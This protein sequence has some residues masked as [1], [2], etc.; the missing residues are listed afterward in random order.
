MPTATQPGLTYDGTSLSFCEEQL[1]KD[2]CLPSDVRTM[3]L[4]KQIADSIDENI[5]V[6]FDVPSKYSDKKVPILDLKNR[7]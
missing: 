4:I 7:C 2:E 6:S 3:N 1:E 5:S